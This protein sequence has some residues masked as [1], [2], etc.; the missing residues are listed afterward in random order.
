M[1]VGSGCGFFGEFGIR[2]GWRSVCGWDLRGREG[3]FRWAE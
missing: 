3:F 2:E 1:C